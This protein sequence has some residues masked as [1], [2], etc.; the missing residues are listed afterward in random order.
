MH[1]TPYHISSSTANGI[2]GQPS[3][4]ADCRASLAGSQSSIM[5]PS[6]DVYSTAALGQILAAAVQQAAT[7]AASSYGGT[8][9]PSSHHRYNTLPTAEQLAH[10]ANSLAIGQQMHHHHHKPSPLRY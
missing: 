8:G 2:I 4:I 10:I 9:T 5:P 7:N 3:S 6:S 1:P